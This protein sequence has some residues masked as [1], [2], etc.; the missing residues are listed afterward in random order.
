MTVLAEVP[1]RDIVI[2]D[3]A[4]AAKVSRSLV[5]VYFTGVDELLSAAHRR[6]FNPLANELRTICDTGED[7]LVR[8]H[9]IIAAT[10]RFAAEHRTTYC[11]VID[12]RTTAGADHHPLAG[13]V[14]QLIPDIESSGDSALVADAIAAMIHNGIVSWLSDGTADIDGIIDL[15]STLVA[16]GVRTPLPAPRGRSA[17]ATGRRRASL[18]VQPP[19]GEYHAI[20][21]SGHCRAEYPYR[22]AK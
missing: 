20:A 1:A 2:E 3:I 13:G 22:P 18:R 14:R 11:N 5:Y 7:P 17:A 15:L 16:S 21:S 9:A 10:V 19:A 6:F 8:M 12:G 4:A